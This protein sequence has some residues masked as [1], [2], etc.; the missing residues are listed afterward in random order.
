MQNSFKYLLFSSIII[1]C[2]SPDENSE[3]IHN[4]NIESIQ[5]EDTIESVESIVEPEIPEIRTDCNIEMDVYLW[6]ESGTA[7]N[8]R[9]VPGGEVD[10]V[11]PAENDYLLGV[12]DLQDGWFKVASIWA[13][14]DEE[15]IMT[16]NEGWIHSSVVAVSTR[17]YG[18][19]ELIIYESADVESE[20]KGL[21]V[22]EETLR[23][24]DVCEEWAKIKFN[25]DGK[26]IEGWIQLE[27]LCGNPVTN[28][29]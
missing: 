2:S 28:C 6:D 3:P 19:Q 15:F 10:V 14:S 11:L 22:N 29:C 27:W 4:E 21:I 25:R 7:T 26:M 24:L 5:M 8:I 12:T 9:E 13:A 20:V 23:I 1:S 16:D 17:N 18:G